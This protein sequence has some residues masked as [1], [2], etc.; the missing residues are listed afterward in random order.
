MDQVTGF[1]PVAKQS[2]RVLILGSMPGVASL[3]KEQYYALPQN[4]FWRVMSD[5]FGAHAELTYEERL[6]TLVN[7]G[8]ALWDVLKTCYRPGSLDSSIVA[9]SIEVNDFE[10][11]YQIHTSI[12]HVFFNGKKASRLYMQRVLPTITPAIAQKSYLTLPST[13]PAM[14]TMTYAEKLDKWAAVAKVM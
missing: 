13:S 5:L 6:Q 3:E 12:R 4:A 7:K 8:V 10:A 9:S 11:L 14:A 1:P 2:A